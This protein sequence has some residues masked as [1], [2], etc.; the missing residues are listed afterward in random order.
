MPNS[1]GHNE[2]RG[3]QSAHSL[4]SWWHDLRI[5]LVFLSR[6]P[7][8]TDKGAPLSLAR[9]VRAFGLAGAVLGVLS[10]VAVML[11]A[12]AGLNPTLSSLIAIAAAT[13]LTGALHEDALADV[14]DG[15]GSGTTKERKLEIMRDSRIGAFGVLALVLTVAA[16]IFALASIIAATTITTTAMLV[17]AIAILSRAAMGTMMY[18]LPNARADGLSAEAGRPDRH[19]I[20]QLVISSLVIALALLWLAIGSWP[21][22]SVLIM[23]CLAFMA[24]KRLSHTQIGGQTG[25]VLGAT[26]QAVEV[27]Q[28]LT[29]SAILN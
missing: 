23:S 21:M 5:C 13:L 1:D 22:I 14:A 26:Q 3:H 20:R 11:A 7:I 27:V 18:Q 15:F 17:I 28:L 29:I 4:G 8:G 12:S 25:D 16:R 6:L 10:A 9:S 19:A 24:M 2:A